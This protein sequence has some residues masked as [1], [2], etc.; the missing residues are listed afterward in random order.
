MARSE[1]RHLSRRQVLE[2]SVAA[3]L[4]A[5]LGSG[6]LAKGALAQSAPTEVLSASH[7]G[8]F[9]ATTEGGRIVKVVPHEKDP[10]PSRCLPGV[11]D[12]M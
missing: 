5:T 9:R 7:W 10:H 12:V 8:A 6:I 2:G 1:D 4:F 3:G 11:T